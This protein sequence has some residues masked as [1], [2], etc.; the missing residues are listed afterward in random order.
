MKEYHK[1]EN[2]YIPKSKIQE[3][4][5]ELENQKSLYFE[6]QVIQGRIDLLHEILEDNIENHIPRID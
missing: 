4:I 6:K 5:E 2:L 3:K 1:I